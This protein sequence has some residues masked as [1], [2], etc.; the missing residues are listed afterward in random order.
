MNVI[1]ARFSRRARLLKP[2]EFSRVFDQAIRSSDRLFIILARLNDKQSP[3][4]GLAISKKNAR[5]AID[6]NR[7]K[8]I[9]RESFR[10]NQL[11]L[12]AADFV[13]MAR[14]ITRTLTNQA[15]FDSLDMHW[16]RLIRQCDE[17]SLD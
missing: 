2:A 3:R 12:P 11:K 8:R 10:L 17:S 14:P 9:I 4:L 7:I 1:R 5:L 13:V 16:N 6:R 15:L